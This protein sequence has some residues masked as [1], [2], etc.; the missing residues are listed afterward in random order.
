MELRGTSC[1][2]EPVSHEV[3]SALPDAPEPEKQYFYVHSASGYMLL[4]CVRDCGWIPRSNRYFKPVSACGR[5]AKIRPWP[6]KGFAHDEVSREVFN[7]S[8]S[9]KLE[10]VDRNRTLSTS[11]EHHASICNGTRAAKDTDGL[12]MDEIL[13]EA[14][15]I[16]TKATFLFVSESVLAKYP[17]RTE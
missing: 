8:S 16:N 12:L 7:G 14:S 1:S 6:V 4:R 11:G 15:P 5:T 3:W 17:R 13:R 2:G 9:S 10:P